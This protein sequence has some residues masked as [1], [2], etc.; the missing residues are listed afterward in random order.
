MPNRTQ[1][2]PLGTDDSSVQLTSAV[3]G[4][5]GESAAPSV[6]DPAR[7]CSGG[8]ARPPST[9]DEPRSSTRGVSGSP[10]ARRDTALRFVFRESR[11]GLTASGEGV[12]QNL[13]YGRGS[14]DELEEPALL[15]AQS[16]EQMTFES[17]QH[18]SAVT[19]RCFGRDGLG[20]AGWDLIARLARRHCARQN[21][22]GARARAF[23]FYYSQPLHI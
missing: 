13:V 20:R 7:R 16:E 6:G 18:A 15:D 22:Y 12:H 14:R 3:Q 4:V 5:V 23:G 11:I 2:V 8:D 9:S 17:S 1:A 10:T 19:G 21:N